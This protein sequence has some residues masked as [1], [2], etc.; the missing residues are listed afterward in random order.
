MSKITKN[1]KIDNNIL[2]V[3]KRNIINNTKRSWLVKIVKKSMMAILF[4]SLSLVI[5]NTIKYNAGQN[6]VSSQAFSNKSYSVLSGISSALSPLLTTSDIG[7]GESIQSING[8]AITQGI[9]QNITLPKGSFNISSGGDYTFFS[10]DNDIGTITFPYIVKDSANATST[11]NITIDIID[12]CTLPQTGSSASAC[13][14]IYTPLTVT[15]NQAST[16]IDPTASG[17]VSFTAVFNQPIDV[18]TFTGDDI[19]LTGTAAGLFVASI[20]D[21]VAPNDGTTFEITTY[22][23]GPGTIIANI[24]QKTN[25]NSIQTLS[26]STPVFNEV[27]SSSTD[28]VVTVNAPTGLVTGTISNIFPKIEIP[29]NPVQSCYTATFQGFGSATTV[30]GSILYGSFVP[31]APILPSLAQIIPL[32]STLGNSTGTVKQAGCGVDINV[33]TRFVSPILSP[34]FNVTINQSITQIDPTVTSPVKFTAVFNTPIDV[35]TFDSGDIVLT[36]TAAGLSIVSI[37]QIAPNNNTTFEVTVS[38]TG[39]GTVIAN[40]PSGVS[41]LQQP[42]VIESIA[43]SVQIITNSTGDIYTLSQGYYG[44]GLF[45]NTLYKTTSTG[46]D[47]WN[48]VQ[49]RGFGGSAKAVTIDSANNIYVADVYNKRVNVISIDGTE[50]NYGPTGSNPV[51]IIRDSLGNTYTANK[52][53]NNVT[54]ITPAGVSTVFGTTGLQP[55]G[56][57]VDSF[58]NIYTSNSGSNTVTKITPAGIVSTFGTTGANPIGIV[59]DLTGN[60]YTANK[61]SNNVTKV[62]QNG[63]SSIFGITGSNPSRINIDNNNNIY[64]ANYDDGS[65]SMVSPDGIATIFGKTG[66]NPTEMAV[67]NTG[68]VYTINRTE[69]SGKIVTRVNSN[70]LQSGI[71]SKINLANQAATSTD[72]KV[73]IASTPIFV[74]ISVPP[75]NY[76]PKPIITGTCKDGGR[77]TI[78]LTN[79]TPSTNLLQTIP[80]FVCPVTETYSVLPPNDLPRGNYCGNTSIVDSL[81]NSAGPVQSCG[82][83]DLG[84]FLTILVPTISSNP[85]P[86][87]TGICEQGNSV[88]LSITNG[89]PSTNLLQTLPQFTCPVSETYSIV[90]PANIP[91][92]KYCANATAI[93]T[94]TAGGGGQPTSFTATPSCG[95]I[96]STTFITV[97]VPPTTNNNTPTLNGTCEPLGVVTIK[98]TTG[99]PSTTTQQTLPNFTCDNTNTYSVIPTTQIPN[100]PYC[101]I[102][103]IVDTAGNTA[104]SSAACGIV[105]TSTFVTISIPPTSNNPRPNLSGTCE[106]GG[107]VVVTITTGS[108]STQVLLALPSFTCS[109]TGTFSVVPTVDIPS[110]LY[111]GNASIIDEATN[112]A[113]ATPSCGIINNGNFVTIT[114]PAKTNN[115]KPPITGT[116]EASAILNITITPTNETINGIVCPTSNIFSI[117]P[118]NPIPDGAFCASVVSNRDGGGGSSKLNIPN[119]FG[120]I[121][122]SAQSTTSIASAGPACGI[123]DTST[124]VTIVVPAL[125]KNA[126]P[127]ITGTCESLAN[128]LITINPTNEI[129]NTVCTAAGTYSVTPLTQIPDGAFSAKAKATDSFGNIANATGNGIVD[130][131]TF[132]TIVLPALGTN[133]LPSFTGTC[134]TGATLELT[135][136]PTNEKITGITCLSGGYSI[137][138][139]VYIPTGSYCA[140]ILATDAIGNTA[141]AS[142]CGDI[143]VTVEVPVSTT[144]T[145]PTISGSCTPSTSGGFQVPVEVTIRYGTGSEAGNGTVSEVLNTTCSTLGKYTVKPTKK[146]PVGPYSATAKATSEIGNIATSTNSGTITVVPPQPE[147]FSVITDPYQC[148][149]S[150]TGKVASNYGINE[151]SIKLFSKNGTGYDTTSA[152]T[153]TPIADTAGNYQININYQDEAVFKKGEYKVEYSIKSNKQTVKTDSYVANITDKCSPVDFVT[154]T[155]R[156]GGFNKI[157]YLIPA[158]IIIIGYGYREFKRSRE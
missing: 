92:G 34:L 136:T 18:S 37:T 61:D 30:N 126:K 45:F 79:D 99:S 137:P 65:V 78:T 143:L 74:T 144:D 82:L 121:D 156:T 114:V 66:N 73:T 151:I 111:C 85:R 3:N 84:Q 69:S 94:L 93:D 41:V 141:T 54:K 127:Q 27:D 81:N 44:D 21:Q 130:S 43:G 60:I 9:D 4:I 118:S 53:S 152:Y 48:T 157:L 149:K 97:T 124:F 110:G 115:P 55:T 116:C 158:V 146:I 134:E 133:H 108:P 103:S 86:A 140:S 83:I 26:S 125:T 50:T 106:A 64:V 135:I 101:A 2:R 35:T 96:D 17:P 33:T 123:I 6:P 95:I 145:T 24:P 63:D 11:A 98:I 39:Y 29:F 91:D 90:P 76:T 153:F 1:Q 113:I 20:I 119:F 139:T 19:K 7:N 120:V 148:G 67:S 142:G 80:T 109:S 25:T 131:T 57:A 12:P 15:I 38:S 147:V 40:I 100:G 72:N 155:I 104:D 31:N 59:V 8:I 107:N 49:Q 129:L 117:N 5:A 138:A 56:I 32:D 102:G 71:R 47:T 122:V 150:I 13:G 23:T 154:T 75:V 77:V 51:A 36:G 87:M 128:I 28:N 88:I 62:T 14:S 22:A 89:T 132:V 58:N 42:T 16:Q 70:F 68:S 46:V 10:L 105:D 112:T 52:D